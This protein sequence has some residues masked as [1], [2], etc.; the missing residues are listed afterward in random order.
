MRDLFWRYVQINYGFLFGLARHRVNILRK[1][2][3]VIRLGF[4]RLGS[5]KR[6]AETTSSKAER[7]NFRSRLSNSTGGP[8]LRKR[9]RNS[10]L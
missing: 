8:L 1:A 10:A 9:L 5:T 3:S 6:D 2:A 7:T 4:R